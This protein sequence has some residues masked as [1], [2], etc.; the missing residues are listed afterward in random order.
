MSE[1]DSTL[2][3][4]RNARKVA[5]EKLKSATTLEEREDAKDLKDYV[6]KL[7]DQMCKYTETVFRDNKKNYTR[8][9]LMN[10]MD[11]K[12]YQVYCEEIE[13][14]RKVN[15]DALIT[16]VRMT[17][18]MCE[19]MG[20]EPIYGRLPEKYKKD[21]SLLMGTENRGKEG[22]VETRH[23]IADWAWDVTIGSTVALYIDISELNYNQNKE[24]MDKIAD[25]YHQKF[26]AKND[27]KN[28]INK[29]TEPEIER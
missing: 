13:R 26:G 10:N 7:V 22:V 15:H 6:E 16:Q 18:D 28:M 11:R 21:S 27:A 17:D 1:V 8:T 3:R 20:V 4:I 5:E 12:D 14:A 24:D 9:Q 2:K 25:T 19:Y 23:A 29:M